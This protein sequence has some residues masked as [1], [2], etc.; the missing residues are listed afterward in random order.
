MKVNI[1]NV[2]AAMVMC[3]LMC[4]LGRTKCPLCGIPAK[5]IHHVNLIVKLKNHV[6]GILQSNWLYSVFF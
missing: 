5:K 1:T 2:G 4:A 6:K 3:L